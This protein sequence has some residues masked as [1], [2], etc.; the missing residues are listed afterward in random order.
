VLECLLAICTIV[1]F[2]EYYYGGGVKEDEMDGHVAC[3]TGHIVEF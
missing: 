3:M 1:M 2:S